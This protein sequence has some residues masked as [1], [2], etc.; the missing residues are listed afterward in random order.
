MPRL[1]GSLSATS[2]TFPGLAEREKYPFLKLV[3]SALLF[4][5]ETLC[6]HFVV[7]LFKNKLFC[8][9]TERQRYPRQG[10][11]ISTTTARFGR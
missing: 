1:D 11:T 8:P 10:L 2:G 3:P 9:L 4:I 6:L 7:D 5:I